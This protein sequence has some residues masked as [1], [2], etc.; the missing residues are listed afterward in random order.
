MTPIIP[1]IL[2][3]NKKQ[4][5]ERFQ[6]LTKFAKVIQI[7]F[8]DGKLVPEK[9]TPLSQIPNLKKTKVKFEAHLMIDHP[10]R[11]IKKLKQKGFKKILFHIESKDN[12][13]KTIQEIKKHHLEPWITI[14]PP[15]PLNKLT[16]H[17]K[18]VKGVMF[19]GIKPGK[20]HQTFMP[21]VYKKISQ[22]KKL[23]PQTKTQVDGGA[24]KQVIKKL[25]KLGIDYINSGSYI[26]SSKNPKQ[27]FKELNMLYKKYNSYFIN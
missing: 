15:T 4:F 1:T 23:S 5:E 25:A 26:S 8:M 13:E 14:N 11:Q 24:N 20:E 22:L 27:T 9:S 16:P 21:I 2:T 6:K 19:M 10:L 7:D 17:L 12:P 18:K 3:K